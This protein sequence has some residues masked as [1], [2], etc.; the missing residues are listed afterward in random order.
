MNNN[1][2]SPITASPNTPWAGAVFS[3]DWWRERLSP[4]GPLLVRPLR[5]A[6]PARKNA[7][8]WSAS[9]SAPFNLLDEGIEA[10][11]DRVSEYAAVNT[12]FMYTH[13][14]YG[15]PYSRT[16]NVLAPDHGVAPRNDLDRRFCP[17]WV[18]HDRKNFGDTKLWFEAPNPDVEHHGRDVFAEVRE[19]A[20][21]RGIKVYGRILEPG[22]SEIKGQIRHWEQVTSID[23]YGRLAN[24]P[25]RNHPE[26]RA[27]WAALMTDLFRNYELDGYQWVRNARDH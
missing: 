1:A 13:T 20:R 16:A 3:R 14:Y 21:Q 4:P 24:Q 17:V 15:I 5:Q 11:L 22:L 2:G 19:P 18:R 25:C 6:E 27:W 26:L 12:L 23:I 7:S 10:C 8:L 9:R